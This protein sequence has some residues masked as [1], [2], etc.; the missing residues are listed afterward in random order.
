MISG[1]KS[2]NFGR[3]EGCC[4]FY[5][6]RECV[7]LVEVVMLIMGVYQKVLYRY[8]TALLLICSG[9]LVMRVSVVVSL[10]EEWSNNTNN[11]YYQPRNNDKKK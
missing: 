5:I 7:C 10:E 4:W 8:C 3:E 1:N 2:S 9:K 6:E 11:E